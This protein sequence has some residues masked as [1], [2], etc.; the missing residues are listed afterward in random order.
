MFKIGILG[1]TGYTGGELVRLLTNHPEVE[2][3]FLDSRTYLDMDFSRVYPNLRKKLEKRCISVNI[4]DPGQFDEI[5]VLF[6]ALPHGLSQKAVMAGMRRGIKVIDLSAD[7]RINDSKIY[8]EWY[9]TGHVA[10]KELEMAVY[11]LTELYRREIRQADLIANPG[12]Y[13]TSILLALYPLIKEKAVSLS[14][15]IADAKSGVSGAGRSPHDGG[16]YAQCN[17]NIKAYGIGSHRHT[18]EIE[19]ELSKMAGEAMVIQF[20]PHLTPMNRG[21]LSTI[22]VDN[23]KGLDE[24]ALERIYQS[25]YDKEHFIRLLPQ[26]ELPQTKAVAGSNF[27]DIAH[28]VDERTNKIILVSA[29]DNLIKGAAGQAVQNMNVMLGIEE[30]L[31]INQTPLW[32]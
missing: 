26:G 19:Q 6:C 16:L 24:A 20:T 13:P 1:A 29:I 17:E 25:H 28:I 9:G 27:C 11:G 3:S 7:F 10:Q 30:S 8:E 12:C 4:E 32:P 15:V 18:P 14:G 5:D 31:G 2:I 22:Y 21:I 23:P